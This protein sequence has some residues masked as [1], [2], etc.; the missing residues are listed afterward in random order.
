MPLSTGLEGGPIEPGG[1]GATTPP[2]V[3]IPPTGLPLLISCD[4]A[5]AGEA[6]EDGASEDKR[7]LL[8]ARPCG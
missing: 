2:F 5:N 8:F 7:G 1:A 3:V 6:Y 4:I